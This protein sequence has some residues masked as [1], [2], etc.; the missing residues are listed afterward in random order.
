MI[1]SIRRHTQTPIYVG[2]GV[3][4]KTARE[5]AQGV[6]GVIVGSAIV[7]VL[8]DDTL[9]HSQKIAKCCEITRT[10]KSQINE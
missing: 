7:S 9:S 8:L 6:D 1:A 3:N 10:I 4:E 2:F 5:K